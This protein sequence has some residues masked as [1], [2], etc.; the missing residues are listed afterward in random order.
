MHNKDIMNLGE[1]HFG[2]VK[3]ITS[4]LTNKLYAMKGINHSLYQTEK[5]RKLVMKEIKLLEKYF[6]TD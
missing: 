4:K 5:Q 6:L 3:L 1:G 2:S